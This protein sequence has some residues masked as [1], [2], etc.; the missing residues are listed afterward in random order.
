MAVLAIFA[1]Y[2]MAWLQ[3][4][5]D[6]L[7]VLGIFLCWEMVRVA[8]WIGMVA[9]KCRMYLLFCS[10]FCF[11]LFPGGHF[12]ILSYGMAS[13]NGGCIGCFAYFCKKCRMSQLFRSLLKNCRMS[14]ILVTLSRCQASQPAHTYGCR[15]EWQACVHM[16]L[17]HMHACAYTW[18]HACL[19]MQTY[20]HACPHKFRHGCVCVCVCVCLG[21]HVV[22]FRSWNWGVGEY[23]CVR[24]GDGQR[25]A[26][27]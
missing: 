13:K 16:Q 1:F 27:W 20:T 21:A 12:C 25:I 11:I 26:M 19:H 5:G 2:L 7:A 8:V 14:V 4:M 15:H 22:S 23:T 6:V 3:K 17:Q 18:P 10:L 24:A 9:K